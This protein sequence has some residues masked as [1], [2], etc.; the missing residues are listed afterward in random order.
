MKTKTKEILFTV[1][2][3]AVAY[4]FLFMAAIIGG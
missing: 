3:A 1:A 2:W 4:L